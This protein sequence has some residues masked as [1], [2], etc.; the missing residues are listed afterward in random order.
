M[1]NDRLRIAIMSPEYQMGVIMAN[2]AGETVVCALSTSSPETVCDRGPLRIVESDR[3][4]FQSE[5][6]GTTKSSIMRVMRVRTASGNCRY[7]TELIQFP[8]PD[9]IRPR[10]AR[11]VGQP[12]SGRT[13]YYVI[14]DNHKTPEC[15]LFCPVACDRSFSIPRETGRKRPG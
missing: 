11:I 8:R 6:G 15:F 9:K 2:A 14:C 10:P 12:E 5:F 3:R 7:R 4:V 1:S 13:D